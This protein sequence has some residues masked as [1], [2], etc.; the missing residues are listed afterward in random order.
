MLVGVDANVLIDEELGEEQVC[1]ALKVIRA[2]LPKAQ[3]VV[4]QITIQE[5]AKLVELGREGA[6]G[7]LKNMLARGYTPLIPTPLTRDYIHDTG[8]KLRKSAF[9]LRRKKTI[10]ILSQRQPIRTIRFF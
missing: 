1:T 3:L 8:D 4:A 9:C 5:L 10:P 7:A 6:E 2:K